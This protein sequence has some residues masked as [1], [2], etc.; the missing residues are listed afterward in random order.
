LRNFSRLD[1]AEMKAVDLHTGIE[2]TLLILQTRLR[3]SDGKSEIQVIK[4]YGNLPNVM[5]YASEINQVFLSIISNAI[6]AL[7][8]IN[9]TEKNPVITIQTEVIDKDRVRIKITDN[10]A[11][12]PAN[13]QSRIFDPFFTTKPVGSGTGLGLSV[14]YGIV[15][16]H[17]GNLTCNSRVGDGTELAIEIPISYIRA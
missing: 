5:C 13:I 17:G 11:G 6:E 2:S 15:K 14:S 1:E 7:Q 8:S 9:K 3:L 10:G 12:I 16:K 4:E